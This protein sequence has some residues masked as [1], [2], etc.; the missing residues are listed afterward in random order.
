[1]RKLAGAV[2]MVAAVTLGAAGVADAGTGGTK[3]G[4]QCPKATSGVHGKCVSELAKNK[5]KKAKKPKKGATTTTV[6]ADTT[7][8][9]VPGV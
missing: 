3:M 8:T 1:M 5:P 7:T 2:L 6:P 9:A 4:Q